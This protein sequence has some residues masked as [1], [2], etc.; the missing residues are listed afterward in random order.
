MKYNYREGVTL[1]KKKPTWLIWV[2]ALV[3]LAVGAYYAANYIA[4]QLISMPLSS[5]STADATLKTMQATTPNGQTHLYIPQINVDLAVS[6]DRAALDGN[7]WQRSEATP[8][9]KDALVVC[10][11]RFKLGTNPWE[12]WAKSPFYNLDKLEKGDEIYLDYQ[13]ERYAYRINNKQQAVTEQPRSEKPTLL[14]QACSADG[15]TESF[16]TV[17]AEQVGKVAVKGK[18]E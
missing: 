17:T 10:A 16:I 12:S 11:Q 6:K 13:T 7:A 3:L 8:E 15:Q 2:V 9:D 14:L 4:P 18:A 1:D 5:K